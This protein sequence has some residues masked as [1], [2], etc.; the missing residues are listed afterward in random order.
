MGLA[1]CSSTEP[2]RAAQDKKVA[3]EG[4]ELIFSTIAGVI[5]PFKNSTAHKCEL[6]VDGK[7][8]EQRYF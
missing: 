7:L 2:P 4:V 3:D 5:K 8:V 6:L 1:T